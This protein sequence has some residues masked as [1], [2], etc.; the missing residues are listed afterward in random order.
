M[1]YWRLFY[2]MMWGTKGRTPTIVP[3]MAEDI[4]R[5]MAGKAK[6]LGARVYAVGGIED[7]VH[8]VASVPPSISLAEFIGQIKGG[9]AHFAN[10]TLQPGGHFGWQAEYGILSFGGKQLDTVVTYVLNQRQHHAQQTTIAFLERLMEPPQPGQAADAV[11]RQAAPRS[12]P[13][14][15]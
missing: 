10:H 11:D 14:R 15:G 5:V 4:Y 7:H 12:K 1:P 13:P 8:M 2:H 3:S 6:E 9:S